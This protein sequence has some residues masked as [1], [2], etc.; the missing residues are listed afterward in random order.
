MLSNDAGHE[1]FMST[2]PIGSMCTPEDVAN[3]IVYL[4]SDQSSFI[5]GVNLPVSATLQHRYLITSL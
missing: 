2:I 4:A 3:A 5:T 1:N